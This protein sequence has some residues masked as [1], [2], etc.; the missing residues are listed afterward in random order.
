[1]K[2]ITYLYLI[3]LVREVYKDNFTFIL[4]TFGKSRKSCISLVM[5]VRPSV[6]PHGTLEFH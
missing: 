6:R 5:S 3:S 2:P 4:G 1:M